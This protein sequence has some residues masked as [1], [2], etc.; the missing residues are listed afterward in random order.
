[1]KGITV[2]RNTLDPKTFLWTF[3]CV[4]SCGEV[5]E[6]RYGK[7]IQ[8]LCCTFRCYR[9]EVEWQHIEYVFLKILV[10]LDHVSNSRLV[11]PNAARQVILCGP[12]ELRKPY[13]TGHVAE[14]PEKLI[15]YYTE[16]CTRHVRLASWNAVER[17]RYFFKIKTSLRIIIN[18]K[19]IM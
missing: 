3:E 16:Q 2:G 5:Q 9:L 12:W 10:F 13:N 17:I 4:A 18:D 7:R 15:Y 14:F 6:D 8:V 1:M 19:E 11:G